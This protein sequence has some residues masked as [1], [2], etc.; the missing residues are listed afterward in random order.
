MATIT[1]FDTLKAAVADFTNRTD[2]TA[3]MDTFVQLA[4]ATFNRTL[5]M[6]DQQTAIDLDI[7]DGAVTLPAEVAEL[8]SVAVRE[9]TDR[10]LP[11]VTVAEYLDRGEMGSSG[12]ATGYTLQGRQLLLVPGA[13]NATQL[14]LRYFAK[15]APLSSTTPSNWLLERA[16]DAYLYGTCAQ[17]AAY[18]RDTEAAQQWEGAKAAVL[19]AEIEADR[20]ARYNGSPLVMRARPLG[21]NRRG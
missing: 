15:L 3:Q 21:E 19:Q 16:P 17:V 7:V 14:R 5:R 13:G 8:I 9:D 10:R 4:E 1:D 18:L 11:Y 2:L 6:Q 20:N 12:P